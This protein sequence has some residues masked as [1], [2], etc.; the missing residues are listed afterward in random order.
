M[1]VPI[2]RQIIAMGG[3]IVK[4]K[5]I[6]PADS[7]PDCGSL[8]VG[9]EVYFAVVSPALVSWLLLARAMPDRAEQLF[10][11]PACGAFSFSLTRNAPRKRGG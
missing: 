8:G 6:F 11:R 3:L 2:T 9:Q 10:S 4:K 1:V 7:L 5:I